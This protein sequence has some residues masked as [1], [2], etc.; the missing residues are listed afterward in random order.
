M[1]L[2]WVPQLE[3]GQ[4]LT[5][6]NLVGGLH[7]GAVLLLELPPVGAVT[8]FQ[9]ADSLRVERI[10]GEVRWDLSGVTGSTGLAWGISPFQADQD[11]L[12]PQIPWDP[13]G[14]GTSFLSNP[15]AQNLRHWTLKTYSGITSDM[16]TF[17]GNS[18]IPLVLPWHYHVD[19]RPKQRVG[20]ESNLWPCLWASAQTGG[21]N[22][23]CRV[24]STLRL[25]LRG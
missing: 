11:V 25:L 15:L 6:V 5:L 7:S 18:G 17:D 16:T 8:E 1:S 23:V 10:V 9:P 4:S 2:D 22:V 20:N 19:I 3:Y 12:V 14:V 21:A 24:T 13:A